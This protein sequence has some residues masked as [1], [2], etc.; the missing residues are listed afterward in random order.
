M[1]ALSRRSFLTHTAAA[2]SASKFALAREALNA[3]SL[4]VEL[5]TVRKIILKDPAAV[6]RAIGE[7]GYGEIEPSYDNVEQIWSAL[8]QTKLKAPATHVAREIFEGEPSHL[9]MVLNDIKERGFEYAVLSSYPTAEGGAD[10]VKRAAELMNR[11]GER[12]KANGLTFCYHNHAHDFQPVDGTPALELV[13]KQTDPKLVQLEMDIFWVTVGGHDPV[14]LLKKYSGRV[15][16]M[17]LKDKGRD[18]SVQYNEKVPADGFKEVGSG[19][20]DIPRVL[21]AAD[22]AGVR[23]YFVEQDQTPGDPIASLRQSYKY[24]SAQFKS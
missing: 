17:H 22:T 14:E 11:V 9:E 4:G 1:P 5:Y 7:I 16:L 12:A 24:L 6:L 15:P 20:I 23:H 8:K 2:I 13:L 18:V 3:R 10:G 21:G 19:T